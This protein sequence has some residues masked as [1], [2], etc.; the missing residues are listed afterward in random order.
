MYCRVQFSLHG[1]TNPLVDD[2]LAEMAGYGR[3][4]NCT[5]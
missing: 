2:A 4:L 3:T 5:R 1:E